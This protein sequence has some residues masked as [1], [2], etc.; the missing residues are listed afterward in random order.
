MT[1]PGKQEQKNTNF[2]DKVSIISPTPFHYIPVT[3]YTDS[4]SNT[5]YSHLKIL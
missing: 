4:V 1:D 5:V 3:V 2:D